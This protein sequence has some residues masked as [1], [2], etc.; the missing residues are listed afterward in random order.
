M[1]ST[2]RRTSRMTGSPIR[3][4]TW[5]CCAPRSRG[6]RSSW[7]RRRRRSKRWS[8]SGAAGTRRCICR[9]ATR[10]RR[11]RRSNSSIC[12]GSGWRAGRFLAAPLVEAAT[13]TLAAGEQ[14]LFFLNRRGYAPLTLC[15]ACGH[16]MQCPSCTAWL[17]EHRFTGRLQ[18]H[19]CGHA[20]T[21]PALCPECLASGSLVPCGP[22][23]E[24]I[25][26]EAAARFPGGPDRA[27]GQRP[28]DRGRAP[29]PSWSRR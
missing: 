6:S 8:I 24:R 20:E 18:C 7:Y 12:G 16:R 13:R 17:V 22:G 4:A 28:A 11:C 9:A 23:V 25:R 1:R 5:R 15:R 14:V 3:R 29:P 19:H 27:D 10:K 2:T 21:V 26:E